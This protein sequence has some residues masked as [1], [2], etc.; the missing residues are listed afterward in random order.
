MKRAFVRNFSC[1]KSAMQNRLIATKLVLLLAIA[2]ADANETSKFKVQAKLPDDAVAVQEQ[3]NQVRFVIRSPFGISQAKI[4]R[5]DVRWPSQVRVQLHLLGL[6]SLKLQVDS[7]RIEAA[8]S[9]HDGSMRLW[10][11]GH[12]DMPLNQEHRY[13]MPIRMVDQ[14]GKPTTS[15]PHKDGWFEFTLPQAILEANPQSI[16]LQWI[17]FYRN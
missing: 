15:L 14:D 10:L 7:I 2:S 6:E 3:E 17:D 5:T 4:E 12:E 1:T 13:W 8:V 11:A 9:S 16:T